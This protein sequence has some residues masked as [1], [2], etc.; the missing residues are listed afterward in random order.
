M[1]ERLEPC[2]P[3]SLRSGAAGGK[4]LLPQ[5]ADSSAPCPFPFLAAGVSLGPSAEA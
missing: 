1:N 3:P 2:P 5:E 4:D